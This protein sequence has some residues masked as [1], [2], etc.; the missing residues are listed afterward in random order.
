MKRLIKKNE[1]E[2]ERER[3]KNLIAGEERK[4]HEQG[5]GLTEPCG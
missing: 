5:T 3:K 2:K 4:R 1:R